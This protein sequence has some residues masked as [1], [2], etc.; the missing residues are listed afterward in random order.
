MESKLAIE[1]EKLLDEKFSDDVALKFRQRLKEGKLTKHENPESHF[2]AYFAACDFKEKQLFIGH[3]IKS[4]LR[5]FN[6]GHIDEGE[7]LHETVI[8]E[9][10]EEWGLDGKDFK[11]EAP[12]FL[13][14]TDIYNPTKQTCRLHLDVWHFINVNK[15]Y[16]KPLQSNL[17]QEFHSVE[18]MDISKARESVTDKSTLLALDFI[19]A[20][21]FDK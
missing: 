1:L 6:G 4:G 21:Y 19:E 11:I 8:R 14:T 15:N 2:C 5:L 13:T 9:I 3:H 10:G 12:A 18:W 7:T 17:A 20:N 16:F